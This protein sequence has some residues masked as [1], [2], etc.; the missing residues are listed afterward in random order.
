MANQQTE[1]T[2]IVDVGQLQDSVSKE[3]SKI[4]LEQTLADKKH[5]VHSYENDDC[6]PG[7]PMKK[8]KNWKLIGLV[9]FVVLFLVML[10]VIII[11]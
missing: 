1:F 8:N 10:T 3:K 9:V 11:L 4:G 7:E 5:T 2:N 6:D